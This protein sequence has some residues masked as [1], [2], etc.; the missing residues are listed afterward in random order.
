[1]PI[2]TKFLRLSKLVLL[3]DR[4]KAGACAGWAVGIEARCSMWVMIERVISCLEADGARGGHPL[5]S[6]EM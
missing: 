4:I 2:E 5:K 3:D 1:M 6:S